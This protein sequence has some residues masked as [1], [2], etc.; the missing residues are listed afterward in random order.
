MSS[1]AVLRRVLKVITLA[2]VVFLV[3]VAG[4]TVSVLARR[5]GLTRGVRGSEVCAWLLFA[6]FWVGEAAGHVPDRRLFLTVV[7][8]ATATVSA[9]VSTLAARGRDPHRQLTAAFA[10]MGLLYVP[11]Q[12]LL[13]VYHA[14]LGAVTAHTVW[15]LGV[16]GFDP[17]LEVGVTGQPTALRFAAAPFV[18]Y[19]IVS[20]CTGVNAIALFAGIVAVAD[21]SLRR[22]VA[23]AVAVGALV[24]CL[25]VVRTVVVGGALGGAWFAFARPVVEPLFGVTRPPV[26]SFYFAEYL[27]V[28]MLVVVVLSGVYLAVVRVLPSVQGFVDELLSVAVADAGGFRSRATRRGARDGQR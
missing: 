11:Y 3:S 14:V 8:V 9:Y 4:F 27:L 5:G 18:Q 15:G 16:V 10:V 6:G 25:N 20:A 21:A 2:D 17:A 19:N 1:T 26:V 13:P 22:R 24:Y 7:S 28:Q 12:F 23:V